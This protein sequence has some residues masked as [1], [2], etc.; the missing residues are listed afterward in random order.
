MRATNLE[1]D[2]LVRNALV[3]TSDPFCFCQDFLTHLVKIVKA[4]ACT[5]H[6][7]VYSMF[8]I[9]E[10][11]LQTD[12]IPGKCR[13]SPQ[14]LPPVL[15]L[16][17]CRTSGLLVHISGPLGKK[18]L[19]TCVS[20]RVKVSGR[21]TGV[22]LMQSCSWKLAKLSMQKQPK[23]SNWCYTAARKVTHQRLKHT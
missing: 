1:S 22:L 6:Q 10:A 3:C 19:P 7:S 13:N 21:S 12:Y 2:S 16:T 14:S 4:L 20:V 15:D 8:C 23:V 18:S 11:Q 9:E 17:S 5:Q